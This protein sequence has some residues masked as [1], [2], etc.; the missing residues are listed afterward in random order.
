MNIGRKLLKS[1]QSWKSRRRLHSFYRKQ[2]GN[3][4][5]AKY[6]LA[7]VILSAGLMAVF[8]EASTFSQ[9]LPRLGLVLLAVLAL[10]QLV[11]RWEIAQARKQCR[12]RFAAAEFKKRLEQTPPSEILKCLGQKISQSYGFILQE[13]KDDV[14]LGLY[15][16]E[17][18]ALYYR[19]LEQ[20]EV[21]QTQDMIALLRE[22][23]QQNI[24][25]VRVFVNT[26]FS[27]KAK[28]LGERFGVN[29]RTY[30]GEQ[31]RFFL[32]DTRLYPTIYEVD[33]LIKKESEK[34]LRRLLILRKEAVQGNKFFV[35]L[36]YGGVLLGM[37]WFKIGYYYWNLSFGLVM[38][39]LA[40]LSLR[41]AWPRKE[42][43]S[44]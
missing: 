8:R 35:Y 39:A 33:A 38:L 34:Q 30:N 40:L 21:L 23:R 31:L 22:C 7:A 14:L 26:D 4:G 9:A 44:F 42:E 19:H 11:G 15:E 13:V 29:L 10:L 12:E 2:C 6:V 32:V 41:A 1:W 28:G 25:E 36:I 43:T 18:L 20:E 16:G 3:P 5:G 17:K 27:P 37:A 24:S